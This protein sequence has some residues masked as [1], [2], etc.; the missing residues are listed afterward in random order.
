MPRLFPKFAFV[1]LATLLPAC[2]S[3]F[4]HRWQESTPPVTTDAAQTIE[5][6]WEG[7]W[8]SNGQDYYNGICRAVITPEPSSKNL[9]TDPPG[10]RYRV[11]IQ[12]V[13]SNVI[14]RNFSFTLFSNPGQ[15]GKATLTG[16]KDFGNLSDG[17]YK[18]EGDAEGRALY[19][20][21]TSV[22]D[23]GTITLRRWPAEQP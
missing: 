9:P 4:D 16:E 1:I 11:D 5:G 19:L 13:Y 23:Y 3:A 20:S 18:Y 7:N 17:V 10:K 6:K 21:F 14:P 15:D 12:E 22:K 8:Y 2:T